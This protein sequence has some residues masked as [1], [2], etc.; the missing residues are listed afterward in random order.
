MPRQVDSR[1]DIIARNDDVDTDKTEAHTIS[2]T[3]QIDNEII[4]SDSWDD[5]QD[6]SDFNEG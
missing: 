6:N 5:R 4:V 3:D 2:D 1:V